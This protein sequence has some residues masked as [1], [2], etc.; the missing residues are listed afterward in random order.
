MNGVPVSVWASKMAEQGPF[1]VGLDSLHEQIG[2]PKSWEQI[3]GSDF[4][5]TVVL[6][7]VNEIKDIRVPWF[8]VQGEGTR[9]LV[10]TLVNVTGSVVED[11]HHWDDTVGGTVSTSNVRTSGSNV[12]DV[13]T[14]TTGSLG[15]QG[16][17]L[18]SLVDT[19][20]GVV[21]HGDKETRG[22]LW[23]RST[24]VEQSWGGM[25]E[26]SL[27]HQVVGFNDG[28]DITAVDTD[29]DSHDQVLWSLSN[30]TVDS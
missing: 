24:S 25:G 14:N 23:V 7:D 12:V 27:R 29:G 5:L 13:Q 16:T 8:Q 1:S 11:T 22:H 6:S 30:L 9:S 26:V 19:F 10:T 15:D 28:L 18:Q 17:L 2:N 21:L 20:D 3:S 4:F